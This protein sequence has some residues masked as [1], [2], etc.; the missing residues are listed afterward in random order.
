MSLH[1]GDR[2][3]PY[4]ILAPIGAGGMGTGNKYSALFPGETPVS[5][6]NLTFQNVNQL[7]NMNLAPNATITLN[8]CHAGYGGRSSIAQ[9]IANQLRRTVYAYSVD[10][11]FSSSPS[12]VRYVKGM[13]APTSLPVYM[14]P[15]GDGMQPLQFPIR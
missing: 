9:L 5:G 7:S 12:A 13:T 6:S 10:M 15:N 8:A 11:Y 2:R 14:V 1:A 3:G 4:E